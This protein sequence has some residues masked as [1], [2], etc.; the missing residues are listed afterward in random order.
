MGTIAE[1]LGINQNPC[2]ETVQTFIDGL[3]ERVLRNPRFS[4]LLESLIASINQRWQEC[5]LSGTSLLSREELEIFKE[6]REIRREILSSSTGKEGVK[7]AH[8]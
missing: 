5:N 8:C 3:E 2:I 4:R 1:L 6:L 7:I